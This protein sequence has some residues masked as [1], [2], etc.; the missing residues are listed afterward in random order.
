MLDEDELENIER[1][2][3]NNEISLDEAKNQLIVLIYK[4]PQYFGMS[5]FSKDLLHS[6]LLWVQKKLVQV[7]LQYDESKGK[8]A[9]Y[10]RVSMYY[11]KNV[12][13][14]SLA[15]KNLQDK[16]LNGIST[17]V[18]EEHE[19]DYSA[20]EQ[21]LVCCQDYNTL[22]L[23]ENT[24]RCKDFIDNLVAKKG[25]RW[26]KIE[27]RENLRKAA[28]LIF[29]L[30]ACCYVDADIIHKV[31]SVTKMSIA[32]IT[33]LLQEVQEKI[34]KKIEKHEKLIESL[35]A[36]Y[37]FY[38]K[39]CIQTEKIKKYNEVNSYLAN[40]LEKNRERHTEIW[41]LRLEQIKAGKFKAVPS[42]IDL[43]K[44]L[45]I[46]DRKIRRLLLTAEK[47]IDTIKMKDYDINHETIF[48]YGQRKQKEGDETNP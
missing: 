42:N 35:N 36:Q 5:R 3:K 28:C 33:K 43:S 9:S 26:S 14:K 44:V 34:D 1:R 40:K 46:P 29:T 21:E 30:K 7:F 23:T 32:D 20:H 39:Y 38:Q 25:I 37:I 27:M 18:Q 41:K 17:L 13:L 6:F 8:F 12:F 15:N 16:V 4:N 10:C 22:S 31:S 47:N 24:V 48:G 11:C 2:F 19:Y 45:H